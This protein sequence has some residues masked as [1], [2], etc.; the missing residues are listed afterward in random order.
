MN[1]IDGLREEA[2]L[3]FVLTT[4]RPDQIEAPLASR[5]GRIDQAVEIEPEAGECL[6][7]C[8]C[9]EGETDRALLRSTY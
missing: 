2:E 7:N 9:N 8:D 4:N 1:E 6:Q 3:L 5:P